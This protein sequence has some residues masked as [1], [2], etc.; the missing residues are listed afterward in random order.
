ME[1]R[2]DIPISLIPYIFPF[3][4]LLKAT[5]PLISFRSRNID[6]FLVMHREHPL[7]RYLLKSLPFPTKDICNRIIWTFGTQIFLVPIALVRLVCLNICFFLWMHLNL[8]CLLLSQKSHLSRLD[9]V[10]EDH[11]SF[12]KPR[13]NFSYGY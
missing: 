8:Q 6:L 12:S 10:W 3:P 1:A 11:A 9:R 7:S 4:M 5:T 13:P 2:K